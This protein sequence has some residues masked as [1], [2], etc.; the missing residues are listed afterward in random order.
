MWFLVGV[1][2]LSEADTTQHTVSD[3][4]RLDD[5]KLETSNC[6]VTES[7]APSCGTGARMQRL[8]QWRCDQAEG[9]SVTS[10]SWN[11]DRHDLVA[12][13]YGSFVFGNNKDGL[14]CIWSFRNPNYPL[15]WFKVDSGVTSL[16]FSNVTGGVLAIGLSSGNIAVYDVKSKNAEPSISSQGALGKHHDPV[17]KVK[18]TDTGNIASTLVSI[19]TDGRVTRWKITKGLEYNDLMRL[20]RVQRRDAVYTSQRMASIARSL[21]QE[22]FISRLTAGTAFDFSMND[23][24][25]YLAGGHL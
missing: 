18:W 11:T 21:K 17:W 13:G 10:M 15:W 12:V 25:I 1:A 7:L 2:G 16:D 8:W 9:R 20:K 6:V 19:S 14:V 23:D 4:T 24:R 22:A 5:S 3:S